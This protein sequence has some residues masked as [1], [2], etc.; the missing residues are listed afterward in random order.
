M[1]SAIIYLESEEDDKVNLFSKKWEL[2]KMDSIKKMI[3]EY[4]DKDE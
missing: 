2:S 4:E 1:P 3:R